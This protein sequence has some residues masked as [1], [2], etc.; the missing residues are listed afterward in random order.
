MAKITKKEA[1]NAGVNS[2]FA[3]ALNQ[4]Q[5]VEKER[6]GFAVQGVVT[7]ENGAMSINWE[8]LQ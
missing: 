3:Y 8:K 5:S 7:F 1:L 2:V 4:M 6:K